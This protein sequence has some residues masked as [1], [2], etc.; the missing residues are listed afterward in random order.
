MTLFCYVY[1]HFQELRAGFEE[2]SRLTGHERLLVTA[3]VAAG[4]DN[5]DNGYEINK[6]SK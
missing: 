4:K 6:I 5:I 3:A 2:E 1:I